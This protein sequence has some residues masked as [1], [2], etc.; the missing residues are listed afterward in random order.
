METTLDSKGKIAKRAGLLYLGL[1]ITSA[2]GL[3]YV[4]SQI[5]VPDDAATTA[6]NMLANEFLFRSGIV[7]N[8]ISQTIFVFLVLALYQL[9]KEVRKPLAT[10]MVA[11]V[12]VSIPIVFVGEVFEIIPLMILKGQVLTT[13]NPEQQQ[14]WSMLFLKLNSRT[15]LVAEI[16]WGLW[17]I[18]FG[19][20]AYKS[21]FIPKIIG[22]LLVLGGVAYVIQVGAALLFPDYQSIVSKVTGLFPTVAELSTILWL[23][24]KGVSKAYDTSKLS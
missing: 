21:G 18:P 10:V 20:L 15:I 22:V 5:Y 4:H 23:L 6:K 14:D 8:L 11:L 12:I 13:L 16:F 9:F 1:A 7:S 17:L 3:I 2:Y 19:Q 24:I